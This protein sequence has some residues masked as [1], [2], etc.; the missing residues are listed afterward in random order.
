VQVPTSDTTFTT[1]NRFPPFG[2]IG[3]SGSRQSVV[4]IN[5]VNRFE[6]KVK[7]EEGERA[8]SN[9]MSVGVSTSYVFLHETRGRTT[10][11]SPIQTTIRIQPPN[12]V[13][14]DVSLRH[15]PA[16]AKAFRAMSASLSLRFA[17]GGRP[18][19][20]AAI[21]LAGNEAQTR[22][23]QD[24]LVPWSLSTSLSYGAS[25]NFLEEWTHSESANLVAQIQPTA[26]WTVNYYNQID[27]N[28]RRIVAQEWAVTRT[29]H[30][31]QAQFVRRFSGGSA[32]YYFRIG[33][34]DRPE[35]FIDRGTSGLGTIGGLGSIGGI[36]SSLV[37]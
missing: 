3:L 18:P 7:T 1:V 16:A 24:M 21:P 30:C 14:G 8:L 2:G 20:V 11:W 22:G 36:G 25:R 26:N 32:D 6:A 34:L 19:A 10:P 5:L 29:L 35:I 9:L 31:W 27:L 15:D 17:G 28:E 33:I 4:S 13:S 37:P 12:Y 23:P